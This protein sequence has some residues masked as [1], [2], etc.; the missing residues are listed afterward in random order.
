M[1]STEA[2][3]KL[4]A[5]F[6]WRSTNRKTTE[7]DPNCLLSRRLVLLCCKNLISYYSL[8]S[9]S[10]G[11]TDFLRSYNIVLEKGPNRTTLSRSA[12]NDVYFEMIPVIKQIVQPLRYCAITL[13]LW[14]DGYKRHGYITFNL[15]CITEEFEL[16]NIN[17]K[18]GMMPI[19]HGAK[20]IAEQYHSILKS[21]G[22]ENCSIFVVT[23]KGSNMVKFVN[24]ENLD[25]QFCLG[26]GVHNLITVDGFEDIPEIDEVITKVKKMVRKLRFRSAQLEQEVRCVCLPFF[27]KIQSYQLKCS[28]PDF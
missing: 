19:K 4:T 24:D 18:T 11:F 7:I 22:I 8:S 3:N 5:Y 17:L 6:G 16:L 2:S 25:H 12:L 14:M 9:E 26:H 21:F 23:D 15:A 28:F 10:I 27:S 13:D 20:E 1:S